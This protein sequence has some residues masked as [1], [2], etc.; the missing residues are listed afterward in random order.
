MSNITIITTGNTHHTC[1]IR[2]LDLLPIKYFF[3][4]NDLI[5]F[6]KN[7]HDCYFIKLPLY[8]RPYNDDVMMI[9]AV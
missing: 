7:F 2:D 9:G 8:F 4:L 3:I 6:I 5:I 1:R